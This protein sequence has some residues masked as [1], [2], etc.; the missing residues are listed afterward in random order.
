MHGPYYFAERNPCHDGAPLRLP[1]LHKAPASVG[2]FVQT[3]SVVAG[4]A[5][6][7]TFEPAAYRVEGVSFAEARRVIEAGHYTASLT[8]GRHCFGLLR[9]AETVG[10]AVFGQPS[11]R[12]V[13][14]SF[15]EH[16]NERNTLELLRLYIDDSTGRN[17]ESWFLSRAL[18]RL[19]REVELVVAYASP[20]VGHYGACYQAANWLYLGRSRSGQNYFY[21]DREGRYVNK[22]IPWQL[23][24]RSGRPIS[25]PEAVAMLG[26]TRCDEGRK[27]VYAFPRRRRLRLLRE[28]LPYPKPDQP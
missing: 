4:V 17:A 3:A 5:G 12:N 10:V 7:L 14:R 16:G 27:H 28:P 9:D 22:R 8:K 20:G 13:A 21:R 24:P 23:G 19:P 11:G 2:A 26:L 18:R 15:I 25:E 1:R 6:G